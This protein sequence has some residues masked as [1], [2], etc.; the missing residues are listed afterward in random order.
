VTTESPAAQ[1]SPATRLLDRVRREGPVLSLPGG[2]VGVFNPSL[3]TKVDKANSD[4]LKI[5][6]SLVDVLKIRKNEPVTW[7]EARSLLTE[8]SG[9]L[10]TPTHMKALYARMTA[11]LGERTGSSEDLTKLVWRTVSR[12]LIPLAIEGVGEVDALTLVAEQ[13]MRFRVQLEQMV[14]LW[15]RLPDFFV[16]RRATRVLTR[17]LKRRISSGESREDFAQVLLSLVDRIGIDRV[18]YLVTVQLIA[19]S[20][21]PGMMA[22]CM[23]YAMARYPEWRERIRLEMAELEPE[24]LYSLPTRKLPCTLRFIKE[25]MRHWATPFVTRRVA[26][27]DIDMDGVVV[28]K[29][30]VYELS[31]YVLH[32]SDEY[33][34]DPE[35]FDPDRWLASRRPAAKG[36]YVP[37]GFGP[38]SCVGA[39]VG[40]GQLILFC[41]LVTRDFQFEVSPGREPRMRMEGFAVPADF[42]GVFVAAAN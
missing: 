42:E 11:F 23:L 40:H 37:F 21:V 28:K 3:A 15:R 22:A 41:A 36:A 20:G 29:G 6:D 8:Q 19:I 26:S 34:D 16:S 18:T 14:P 31:S 9:R 12:A 7:R 30:G 33:W 1:E 10:A 24:E 32:H 2:V 13:E 5:I 25:S 4:D 27:R 38:R 35:V 17:Q 39:S